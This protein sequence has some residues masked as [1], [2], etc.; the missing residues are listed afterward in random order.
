MNR[1][2]VIG[3]A[4]YDGRNHPDR[5]CLDIYFTASLDGGESFLPEQKVSSEARV[6]IR[7]P[8]V[9]RPTAFTAG[10][11]YNGLAAGAD[12]RF[13]LLWS[14]SRSGR[15]GLRTATITVHGNVASEEYHDLR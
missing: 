11:D 10:G 7:P 4:W 2:G 3:I 1:D 14:D 15:F 6:L 9:G 12:G 5:A 13:H 8:T